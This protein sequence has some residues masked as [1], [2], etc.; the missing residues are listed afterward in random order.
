[1]D[2][3]QTA[4]TALDT[5]YEAW[6]NN[7]KNTL[8]TRK[9]HYRFIRQSNQFLRT[10]RTLTGIINRKNYEPQN[11]DDPLCPVCLDVSLA[12]KIEPCG[13]ELCGKCPAKLDKKPL[14]C[15]VCREKVEQVTQ[16]P[17]CEPITAVEIPPNCDNEDND[18]TDHDLQYLG[19]RMAS[20]V[21]QYLADIP[22]FVVNVWPPQTAHHGGGE[23]AENMEQ[24]GEPVAD[25]ELG[26]EELPVMGVVMM[27][28]MPQDAAVS[29]EV[30]H[31]PNT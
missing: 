20:V 14:K 23:Q 18:I 25:D 3:I 10:F 29:S 1:M 28:I 5:E 15:P 19:E 31:S 22:T 24:G 6:V 21:H 16:I 30:I 12:A 27:Q 17:G 7:N 26:G 13:H 4:I 8:Y 2:V 9:L 11:E